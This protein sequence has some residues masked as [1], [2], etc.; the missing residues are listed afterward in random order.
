MKKK[1]KKK[2]VK[3]GQAQNK[4]PEKIDAVIEEKLFDFGGLPERNLKKSLGC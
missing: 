1:V 4:T 2:R 3:D